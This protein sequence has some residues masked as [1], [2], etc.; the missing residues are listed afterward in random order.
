MSRLVSPTLI[1]ITT[2]VR[3]G[4][5]NRRIELLKNLNI[6]ESLIKKTMKVVHQI[7]IEDLTYLALDK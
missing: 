5:H 3:G 4:I 1:T 6:L 2:R 7:A